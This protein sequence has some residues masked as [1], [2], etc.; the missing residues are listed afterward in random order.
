MNNNELNAKSNLCQEKRADGRGPFT[1]NVLGTEKLKGSGYIFRLLC[2]LHLGFFER[3]LK[4]LNPMQRM[5]FISFIILR[6]NHLFG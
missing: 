6:L 3:D 2:A 1:M 4:L 5:G